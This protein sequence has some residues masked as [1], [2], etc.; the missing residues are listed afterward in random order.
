MKRETKLRTLVAV[1]MIVSFGVGARAAL[2]RVD[3]LGLPL[4]CVG[5]YCLF[6][7]SDRTE[8][9][10]R[11]ALTQW[12]IENHFFPFQPL[13]EAK[14]IE[15]IHSLRPI[16]KSDK[17]GLDFR[18]TLD[19]REFCMASVPW[20]TGS[21]HTTQT[22]VQ[23]VILVKCENQCALVNAAI[24][25]DQMYS[26]MRRRLLEV[27]LGYGWILLWRSHRLFE[28]ASVGD[29]IAFGVRVAETFDYYY[30]RKAIAL[31][32]YE[33]E[34]RTWKLLPQIEKAESALTS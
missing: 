6:W 20:E 30:T 22:G 28:A 5:A 19:N 2:D 14:S 27:A 7:L 4:L 24:T 3:W 17:Y 10:T 12:A 23:Q 32:P 21:G 34:K 8:S 33:E 25:S 18:G 11:K 16:G 13:G 1:T 29:D 9:L 31:K 15:L 26:L